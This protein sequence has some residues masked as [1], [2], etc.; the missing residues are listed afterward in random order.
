[1]M[2]PVDDA[3][4]PADPPADPPARPAV[5]PLPP[6]APSPSPAPPSP[7]TSPSP[8]VRPPAAPVRPPASPGLS[9]VPPVAP[10]PR[11]AWGARLAVLAL[12]AVAGVLGWVAATRFLP[13]WWARQIGDIADGSLTAG[14]AAGVTCGVVFTLLPL[15][16]L[17]GTVRRGA[18]WTVRF[19]YLV[20]GFLLAVPNLI[21]LGVVAGSGSSA[22]D[23]RQILDVD[24]QGFRGATLFGVA[25]GAL[26]AVGLW[27]MLWRGRRRDR[28]LADLKARLADATK[29]PADDA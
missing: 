12:A 16:V 29:P 3:Q 10:P 8:T 26:L 23:A 2:R 4:P 17:R 22:A 15:L 5:P 28:Q 19:V 6:P 21:T 25:V 9:P 18:T 14:I 13:T 11:S 20:L 7:P 24:G 27:V 1:M